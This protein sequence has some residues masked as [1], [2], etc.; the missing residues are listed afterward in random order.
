MEGTRSAAGPPS[1]F[2]SMQP[3][4]CD[5]AQDSIMNAAGYVGG[6]LTDTDLGSLNMIADYGSNALE[7]PDCVPTGLGTR[8]AFGFDSVDASPADAFHDTSALY[9]RMPM[10]TFSGDSF[11]RN[12]SI[13]L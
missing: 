11:V 2:T 12:R 9:S 1:T 6:P 5:S 7:A 4:S 13:S 10:N 8:R 3:S